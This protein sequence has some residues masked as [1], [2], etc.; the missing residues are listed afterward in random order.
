MK[1]ISLLLSS[2]LVGGTAVLAQ[3][4]P[5]PGTSVPLT[6]LN[7]QSARVPVGSSATLVNL[8]V[9]TPSNGQETIRDAARGLGFRLRGISVLRSGGDEPETMQRYNRLEDGGRILI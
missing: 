5:F 7:Q 1:Q 2:L 6:S 8:A 9:D 4:G 3:I